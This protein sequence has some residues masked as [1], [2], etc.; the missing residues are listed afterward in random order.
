VSLRTRILPV[1]LGI[2]LAFNAISYAN[3]LTHEDIA[4]A[5]PEPPTTIPSNLDY[6]QDKIYVSTLLYMREVINDA[7]EKADAQLDDYDAA[8]IELDNDYICGAPTELQEMLRGRAQDLLYFAG[9][10]MPIATWRIQHPGYRYDPN[11]TPQVYQ[12]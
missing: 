7:I 12:P 5:E 11:H 9:E 1:A 3:H 8:D 4:R 2:S 6:G 10:T